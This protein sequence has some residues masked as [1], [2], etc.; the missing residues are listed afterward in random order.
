M[1]T[2]RTQLEAI[3]REE[4]V[5]LGQTFVNEMGP[6]SVVVQ[7]SEGA[8]EGGELLDKIIKENPGIQVTP[9]WPMKL[10]TSGRKY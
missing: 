4:K 7:V 1:E 2:I 9:R 8:G 10:G 5:E 6:N 3:C